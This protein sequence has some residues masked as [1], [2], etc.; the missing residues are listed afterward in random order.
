MD[1]NVVITLY[2][3]LENNVCTH[4]RVPIIPC[5]EVCS[6]SLSISY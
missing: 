4:V 1:V 3:S 5:I 2:A 6:D